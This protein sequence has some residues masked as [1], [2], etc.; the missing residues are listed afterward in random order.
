VIPATLAD[1]PA[2]VGKT[3]RALALLASVYDYLNKA[4]CRDKR[5]DLESTAEALRGYTRHEE[6]ISDACE[7]DLCI[8]I[9]R[10]VQRPCAAVEV[11]SR[12]EPDEDAQ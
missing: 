6:D 8:R 1:P 11:C 10:I 3:P 2:A 7:M 5:R 4:K 12:P 9:A